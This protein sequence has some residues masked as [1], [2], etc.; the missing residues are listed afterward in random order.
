MGKKAVE[1]D[2][3]MNMAKLVGFRNRLL[4]LVNWA[5]GYLFFERSVRLILQLDPD[6]GRC[7]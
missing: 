2:G 4:E 6:E 7:E 3:R 1:I 5:G